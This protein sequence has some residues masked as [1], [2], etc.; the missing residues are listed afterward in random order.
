MKILRLTP[1]SAKA[2]DRAVS[3]RHV[4]M[5]DAIAGLVEQALHDHLVIGVERAVEKQ[6]RRS[7]PAAPST[8]SSS[9]AQ[10]GT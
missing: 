4:H 1:R 8:R 3:P 6:E 7:L 10:P 9:L 5:A 2:R